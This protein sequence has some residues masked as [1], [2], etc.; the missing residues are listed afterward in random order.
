MDPDY[1]TNL[2]NSLTQ[3]ISPNTLI[4]SI[5]QTLDERIIELHEQRD[6]TPYA[7]RNAINN[8]I[9]QLEAS[10]NSIP[11]IRNQFYGQNEYLPPKAHP[12]AYGFFQTPLL[13]A[14]WEPIHAQYRHRH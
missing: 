13:P 10:Y 7:D 14:Y 2:V 12:P 8:N 4:D 5:I 9:S 3:V 11:Q 1:V 6:A